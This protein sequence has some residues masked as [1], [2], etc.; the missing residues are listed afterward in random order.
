MCVRERE[1]DRQRDR[2]KERER[3][4]P[5]SE[6]H[7][8]CSARAL[9]GPGAVNRASGGP[10]EEAHGSQSKNERKEGKENKMN[11]RKSVTYSA[12]HSAPLV[13]LIRNVMLIW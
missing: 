12:G 6:Y 10:I 2:E 9:R 7:K 5:I 11:R 4:R 1:T 8:L 13:P 3:E